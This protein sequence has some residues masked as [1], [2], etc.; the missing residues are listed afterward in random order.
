[1]VIVEDDL[2]LS[3][4]WHTWLKKAW[5]KYKD[6]TDLAGINLSVK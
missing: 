1:M 5:A 3:P 4:M 6:R 2:E